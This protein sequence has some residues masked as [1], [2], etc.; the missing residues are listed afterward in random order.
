MTRAGKFAALGL[1]TLLTTL[2]ACGRQDVAEFQKGNAPTSGSRPGALA[3]SKPNQKIPKQSD[4]RELDVEYQKLFV[5]DRR[6]EV[7]EVTEPVIEF[8]TDSWPNLYPID[9]GKVLPV[10]Y[11]NGS[12]MV[13]V[14][15]DLVRSVEDIRTDEHGVSAEV[16]LLDEPPVRVDLLAVSGRSLSGRGREAHFLIKFDE[17][18]ALRP[19]SGKK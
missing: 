4:S 14:P 1:M 5:V 6:G 16:S 9:F 15:W 11:R 3:A 12:G 17:I 2:V 19:A 18:R 8:D 10:K 13:K 7:H